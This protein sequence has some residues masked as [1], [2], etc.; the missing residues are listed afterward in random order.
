MKVAILHDYL[1]QFGGAERVLESILEIFPSAHIYTLLFDN[2]RTWHKFD[3]YQVFASP[4]NVPLVKRHHRFFIP[5]FPFISSRLKGREEYDLVISSTAG[6]SKGFNVKGSF[7]VSYCH[8]PL[9]YAWEIDYLKNIPNF[10]APAL[11]WL[12]APAA[13]IL[14]KWDRRSSARVN[15][16]VANSNFIARKINSYYQREAEVIYPPVD[17]DIFYPDTAIVGQEDSYYLMAGR[18]I[19]YKLFDLGIQAFN[20]LGKKLKI[21]GKGPEYQR[22]KKIAGPNIEFIPYVTD[23]ELRRLYSS[24]EA[25]IFP[26]I[27]D[28]GL[29]AAEAQICGLPVIA[30]NGGGAKEIIENGKTGLLFNNQSVDSLIRAVKRCEKINFNRRYIVKRA[31][32][33]SKQSFQRNFLDLLAKMGFNLK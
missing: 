19:Y 24:A 16:F 33:F 18:L 13:E 20:Q 25:L 27:E 3:R 14:K 29:V 15:L 5:F 10:P 2:R 28:F 7:H 4:F 30:Y 31:Q 22:L 1:N 9:R 12:T 11:S 26:Q 6:Y 32:R 23:H 17:T 8:S 21:V